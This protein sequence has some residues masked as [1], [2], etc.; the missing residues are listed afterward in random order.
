MLNFTAKEIFYIDTSQHKLF[1]KFQFRTLKVGNT[2]IL[3]LLDSI[4]DQSCKFC[5]VI[6]HQITH[7]LQTTEQVK[8]QA[9]L[10]IFTCFVNQRHQPLKKRTFSLYIGVNDWTN[11]LVFNRVR[12]CLDKPGQVYKTTNAVESPEYP[13]PN[14]FSL[15]TNV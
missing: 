4:E 15:K 10:Y 1:Y 5:S 11:V 9:V 2:N 14:L 8:Q 7:F 6:L 3:H 13:V 12:A